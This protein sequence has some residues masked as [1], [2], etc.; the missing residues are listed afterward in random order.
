MHAYRAPARA[1]GQASGSAPPRQ[2]SPSPVHADQ[3]DDH[4]AALLPQPDGGDDSD[5]EHGGGFSYSSQPLK[6]APS[7]NRDPVGDERR[8][9]FEGDAE[10]GQIETQAGEQG[11]SEGEGVVVPY[12][13][14]DIKPA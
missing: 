13:H 1:G 7:R 8:L 3:S 4:H 11:V 6:S 10:L 14:R 5:E 12:A 2:P 9:V